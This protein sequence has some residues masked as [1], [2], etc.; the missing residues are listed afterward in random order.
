[1]STPAIVINGTSGAYEQPQKFGFDASG[2]YCI[3]TWKGTSAAIASLYYTCIADGGTVQYEGGFG[4][5]NLTARFS[6]PS[7]GDTEVPIDSWEFFASHV[8]KDVLETD[9]AAIAALTDADK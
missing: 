7:G 1:M 8:E 5:Y 2:P 4:T 6:I 3:R 9:N